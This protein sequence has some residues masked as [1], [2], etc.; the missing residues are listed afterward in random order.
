MK[1]NVRGWVFALLAAAVLILLLILWGMRPGR[2]G[3][4]GQPGQPAH[5]VKASAA[6]WVLD[7]HD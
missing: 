2:Q 7:A 4:P 6:V 1:R 5:D 3:Q